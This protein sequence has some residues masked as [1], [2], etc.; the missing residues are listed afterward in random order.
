MP[1]LNESTVDCLTLIL[2]VYDNF[3]PGCSIWCVSG[4]EQLEWGQRSSEE[5]W[6]KLMVGS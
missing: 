4:R 5:L 1:C 2:T 6:T 3:I